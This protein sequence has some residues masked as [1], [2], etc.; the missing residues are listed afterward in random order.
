MLGTKI[1]PSSDSYGGLLSKKLKTKLSLMRFKL[2]NI[3]Q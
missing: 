1:S 2:E 3:Q